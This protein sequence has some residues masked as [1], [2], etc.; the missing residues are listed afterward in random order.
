MTSLLRS[1]LAVFVFTFALA[2]LS[3]AKAPKLEG[4][5]LG[6]TGIHATEKGKVLNVEGAQKGSPGE[7][8]VKKGD[9]LIGVNGK[10]FS[11][12]K[13][14]MAK[15]MDL[16]ESE[17]G[18][19]KLSLM[20]KG[21]KTVDLSIQVLG[22]YSATAP[23]RC[24]KTDKIITM[25]AD[26]LVASGKN[27]RLS[28]E[29]LGLMATGEKKYMEAATKMV[30]SGDWMKWDGS[31][32]ENKHLGTW[33]W[34]Y[35]LIAL[36]EYYLLTHDE[37]VLP[38]IKSL[39]ITLAW[40]QDPKGMYGHRMSDPN[41]NF[42]L[43]GYG[44][45]NQTTLSSFI[46]M[47]MARKCGIKDPQLE[48]AIEKTGA[49]VS[50]Y[51]GRGSFPYAGSG[52]YSGGFNNNG[53]SGMGAVSMELLGNKE[54]TK[55][56]A[57]C[58]ATT[59]DKLGQGH[60]SA[61]FNPFWT[62]LGAARSGPAVTSEYFKRILP[63]HN[64]RRMH[65]GTWEP[66][67]KPGTH[68]AVALLTYCVGRRAL[69]ITGREMDESIWAKPNEVEGIINLSKFE[70]KG[71]SAQEVLKLSA[72]HPMPQIRRKAAGALGEHREEMTPT[73]VKWMKSGTAEQKKTAIG[74]YGWWIKPDVKL[75]H[76]PAIAAILTNPEEPVDVRKSAAGSIAYMGEEARKYYMDIVRLSKEANDPGMGKFLQA[77]CSRPFK[78]DLIKTD[79]DKEAVY[80]LAG[81]LTHARDQGQ[82]GQGFNMLIG[83]PA[84]DFHRFADRIDY[85]FQGDD[86]TWTSYS[87]PSNDVAPAVELLAS[88]NIKEGLDYALK[89]MD[90]RPKGKHNFRFRASFAAL[91]AYRGNAKEALK[92]FQERHGADKN[93]GRA[94]GAYKKM[95]E[96]VEGDNNPPKLVPMA[97]VIALGKK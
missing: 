32:L 75:P 88:L 27:G 70:M 89:I 61:F 54:G 8:K 78:H 2:G 48:K 36:S 16:A 67:W 9:V 86:P 59:Y 29:I 52:P 53:M 34:S 40:G 3:Q 49:Y 63:F 22:D 87:N 76:L 20:L 93:Y 15:A 69:I 74:Q 51:A 94:H 81:I 11:K 71:R 38:P 58:C 73:Y 79:A 33:G 92:V 14:D 5:P 83:M 80:E 35:L 10:K 56:F 4:E 84:K 6:V 97:E 65:D 50:Q 25:T 47:L 68:D 64:Q 19:G 60:A 95:I 77:L 41:L 96:I 23:Y 82:R 17:A 12:P 72:E 21:G 18:K 46:G 24:P 43:P 37:A 13:S 39:A 28:A 26:K 31:K 62:T 1:L 85:V 55:F 57:K 44:A 30:K 66:D 91:Q 90:S 7:G 45:M 42:R